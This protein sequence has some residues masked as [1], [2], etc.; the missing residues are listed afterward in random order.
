[1]EC[2]RA[3]IGDCSGDII[4]R[5]TAG[6]SRTF[7]CEEHLAQLQEVLAGIAERYPEVNHP[8]VCGCYGCGEGSW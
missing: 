7:T 1:M 3:W 2:D 4:P 5:I 8:D 6:G